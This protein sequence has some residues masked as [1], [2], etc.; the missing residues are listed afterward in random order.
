[1]SEINK[2]KLKT[3]IESI[4]FTGIRK[5]FLEI[6]LPLSEKYTNAK[7]SPN[8]D[9]EFE[10]FTTS[11]KTLFRTGIISELVDNISSSIESA[12][13]RALDSLIDIEDELTEM[14]LDSYIS[15]VSEIFVEFLNTKDVKNL[16]SSFNEYLDI[17]NFRDIF[18]N[19]FENLQTGDAF[20]ELREIKL[21]ENM[22]QNVE[23]YL[24]IGTIS[25]K[26]DKSNYK[27][28]I[29]YLPFELTLLVHFAY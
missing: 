26:K 21:N 28:P 7:T 3:E 5:G 25:Y 12:Q 9:L 27:F 17:F 18:Y 1:M 19:Y 29:F 11:L 6:V 8:N 14:C 23:F 15:S 24:N 2:R 4:D 22:V 10:F 13:T 20:S 16:D